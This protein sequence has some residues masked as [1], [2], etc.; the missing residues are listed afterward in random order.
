MKFLFFGLRSYISA[1]TYYVSNI[2]YNSLNF[3]IVEFLLVNNLGR[4]WYVY[5]NNHFKFFWKY[6]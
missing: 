2:D 3:S 1:D 5:L 4:V 6:V